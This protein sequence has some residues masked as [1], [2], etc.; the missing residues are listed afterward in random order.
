MG[1]MF[2]CEAA[3]GKE[4]SITVDDHRLIAA[5]KVGRFVQA[6]YVAVDH[7]TNLLDRLCNRSM[8]F[9][10][11]PTPLLCGPPSACSTPSV[12]PHSVATFSCPSLFA[13]RLHAPSQGIAP[14]LVPDRWISR[15]L[16][17]LRFGT[18]FVFADGM[19]VVVESINSVEC[20]KYDKKTRPIT[21]EDII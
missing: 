3:L 19:K 9:R 13:G 18:S 15:R 11:L 21:S 14:F 7:A 2:L 4:A 16:G 12:L 5:P 10:F 8:C 20:C 6:D 1:V 17:V